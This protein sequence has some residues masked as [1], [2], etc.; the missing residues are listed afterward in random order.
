MGALVAGKG[1]DVAAL[2]A[3]VAKLAEDFPLYPGLNQ[4]G[5]GE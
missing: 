3:R 1:A 2:R 5:A 4:T